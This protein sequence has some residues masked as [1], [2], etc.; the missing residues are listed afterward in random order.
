[1]YPLTVLT[2]IGIKLEW[3]AACNEAFEAL[4]N[5]FVRDSIIVPHNS[6]APTRK[7]PDSSKWAVEG[8]LIQCQNQ[9]YENQD[10]LAANWKSVA[11]FSW[12]NTPAECN[13]YTHDKD[14]LAVIR[15]LKDRDS[16]LK[17]LSHLFRILSDHKNLEAFTKV[18]NKLLNERKVRWQ[19]RLSRYRVRL[20]FRPGS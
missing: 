15:C 10:D 13:Y 4:K 9:M 16:E 3:K 7:E 19:E 14:L 18:R 6:E 12:K 11:Y 2:W 8:V 20:Q 17:F 1:M 5:W